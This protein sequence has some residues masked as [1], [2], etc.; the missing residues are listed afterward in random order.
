MKKEHTE[1]YYDHYKDTFEKV[2]I[3][4]GSRL[5]YFFVMLFLILLI[6]LSIQLPQLIDN[7]ASEIVRKT[8]GA[9]AI[10]D[11]VWIKSLLI[12]S[13]IW[14]S[15]L[16]YQSTLNIE[17]LYDYLQQMERKLTQRLGS[18]SISREGFN[19]LNG[20]PFILSVIH[21]VYNTIIPVAIIGLFSYR[22]YLD[23]NIVIPKWGIVNIIDSISELIIVLTALLYFARMNLRP[24]IE[25]IKSHYLI[26][27]HA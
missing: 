11:F 22:W 21:I 1:I 16:Y 4:K 7:S 15:F 20:Y 2:L 9:T 19:Y 25:R 27:K 24:I 13:F 17:R 10:I 8:I 23:N 3:E 26:N 14:A 12:F 5:K 18:L 6:L